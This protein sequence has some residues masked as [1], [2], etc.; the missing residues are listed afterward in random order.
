MSH[1]PQN[2]LGY[3]M[4][5]N[6]HFHQHKGQ[7]LNHIPADWN[8]AIRHA[9]SRETKPERPK[10]SDNDFEEVCE[11]CGY[12][13]NRQPIGLFVP[14]IQ[15]GFLGSGFPLFYNYIQYC[16]IMLTCLLAIQG[17]PNLIYNY[18][19]NFCDK[20]LLEA[21][22]AAEENK[23]HP[24]EGFLLPCPESLTNR[25]SLANVL[26]QEEGIRS[27]MHFSTAA[28]I[29]QIVLCIFFRRSQRQIEVEVDLKYNTPADYTVWVKHVPKDI[30]NPKEAIRKHFKD[31][32]KKVTKVNLIY[33]ISEIEEL[34][35]EFKELIKEKQKNLKEHGFDNKT[36]ELQLIEQKMQKLEHEIREKEQHIV[37]DRT[38]F[39]GQ[40]FVSFETEKEKEELFTFA[41]PTLGSKICNFIT[42]LGKLDR[43]VDSQIFEGKHKILIVEAPEPNDIDWEFI[44][45]STSSKVVARFISLIKWVV[46]I[47][48][49]FSIICLI[50]YFQN[51]KIDHV[52]EELLEL[53]HKSKKNNEDIDKEEYEKVHSSMTI[54]SIFSF[55]ISTSIVLFNKFALPFLVHHIVDAEKWSTKTKLNISFAFKLT[56][57][58][59]FNT[60]LITVLIEIILFKNFYGI[61]GG[62]ILNEQLVFI[63][64]AI[65]PSL[66][67]VIDPWSIIKNIQRNKELKNKEKSVL[68]QGEA[69]KLMEHPDYAMGKRYADIMKTMWFTFFF[70]PVIPIGTFFSL[71]GLILYY[72][73]DK[74]NLIYRRTVKESISKSLSF[75]MMDLQEYSVLLHC[76]GNIAFKWMLASEVDLTSIVLFGVCF[77]IAL[78][79]MDSFNEWLFEI[80]S[81]SESKSYSQVKDQFDTDY[82][83]ENP[84]TKHEALLEFQK[85]RASKTHF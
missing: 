27:N 37:H 13:L 83:R 6:M 80:N 45:S 11:C 72:F 74:Y 33:D 78:V 60:A 73:T 43:Y 50:T 9:K 54:I 21:Y 28:V 17:I 41:P 82:D 34:E 16:I 19:G 85:S 32:N 62:M 23:E 46:L 63:F 56:I 52:Q 65:I 20:T 66:A 77:F 79:P 71:I 30:H 38:K 58:L 5:K 31:Q 81:R 42:S 10:I 67:W 53:Q 68:T 7:D 14:S 47:A 49:S 70:S 4:F 36:Q 1:N 2:P 57:A 61:G 12:E 15:L 59:F 75:E 18:K 64:N 51:L 24:E 8:K 3:Q 69:N 39:T 76:F 22:E 25:I 40:A 55:L 35:E 44:H 48:F 84:I 29:V 26:N